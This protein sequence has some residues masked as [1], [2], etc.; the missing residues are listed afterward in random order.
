MKKY[1]TNVI[2]QDNIP[3]V[4]SSECQMSSIAVTL[5]HWFHQEH[6]DQPHVSKQS[7]PNSQILSLENHVEYESDDDSASTAPPTQSIFKIDTMEIPM[8]YTR[9][10][11]CGMPGHDSNSCRPLIMHSLCES[12]A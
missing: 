1:Y 2:N 7:A 3:A 10:K 9:C 6:L 4:L 12:F 5:G 11:L 8:D